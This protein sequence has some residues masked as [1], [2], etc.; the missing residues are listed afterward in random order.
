MSNF[1]DVTHTLFG[2][3]KDELGDVERF[4]LRHAKERRT[5]A[6]NVN[7]EFDSTQSPGDRM[8]DRIAR[9]GGSW[10]FITGFM[11]F[12]VFWAVLNTIILSREAFDP[13]PFI[14]LNLVLSMIAAI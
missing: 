10:G 11:A 5:L 4:V 6:R 1:D 8:S 9:I 14:F 7:S 2:K 12:L 3:T 13:Y